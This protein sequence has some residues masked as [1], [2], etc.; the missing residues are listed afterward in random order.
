MK[1]PA[2]MIEVIQS[3]FGG[4]NKG[5]IVG[6]STKEGTYSALLAY[7]GWFARKAAAHRME[8]GLLMAERRIAAGELQ[9]AIDAVEKIFSSL[10]R[11]KNTS[12]VYI[13]IITA[14]HRIEPSFTMPS[15]RV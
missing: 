3:P 4:D 2:G 5:V 11:V 10:E 9:A 15:I 8:D 7:A 14:M 1:T 6:G 13:P 12:V